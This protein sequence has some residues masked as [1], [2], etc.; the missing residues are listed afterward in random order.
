MKR[1][2]FGTNET[3]KDERVSKSSRA[4]GKVACVLLILVMTA[5]VLS[6]SS[7]AILAGPTAT[8]TA[9][10]V[11]PT[12]TPQPTA[13]EVPPTATP[14]PTNT[15]TPLPTSTV[16]PSIGMMSDLAKKLHGEGH[17]TST[18]GVYK[19]LPTYD[20]SW[21]QINWFQWRPTGEETNAFVLRTD[22]SWDS[23]SDTA[24]HFNSGCGFVFNEQ[25]PDN[26]YMVYLGL[27]GEANIIRFKGG[28]YDAHWHKKYGKVGN[29]SGGAEFVL[30]V[31]DGKFTFLVDGEVAITVTDA[32]INGKKLGLTINSGTNKDF[33]T[34]C[35]MENIDLWKLR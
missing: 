25:D 28:Y 9:T 27:D 5:V 30:A 19:R 26:F 16:N 13:T 2:L 23:A 18:N 3:Q 10:E 34:H 32:K 11:P 7:A 29:P 22:V 12:H 35:R 1:V 6:C 17:L 8:P 14:K 4:S 21:A 15:R 31:Q 20:E 24:N 33:G